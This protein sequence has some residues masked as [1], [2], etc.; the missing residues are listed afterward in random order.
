MGSEFHNQLIEENPDVLKPVS[1]ERGAPQEQI[2]RGALQDSYKNTLLRLGLLNEHNRSFQISTL[3]RL[4]FR[5]IEA[6][7]EQEGKI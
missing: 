4:L 6:R 3:G 5:Y 1:R 2:D 7:S